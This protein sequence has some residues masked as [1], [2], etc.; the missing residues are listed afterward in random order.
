MTGFFHRSA[1][2]LHALKQKQ[3]LLELPVHKLVTDVATRWN[4]A[5]DM[6]ERFL[7]QQPA[8]TAALLSPDVRKKEKNI[9][10]YMRHV[11]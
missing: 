8:V 11:R 5:F 9:S 1:T 2:A 3:K 10:T 4:S 6:V 7:E